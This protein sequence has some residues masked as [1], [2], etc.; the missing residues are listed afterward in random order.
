CLARGEFHHRGRKVEPAAIRNT[1]LLTVEGTRDDICG[2]GQTKAA[3]TLC[4]GIA[5]GFERRH[6]QVDTGHYGVFSGS[7]WQKEI[8]PTVRDVIRASN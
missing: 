2:I 5:A 7:R 1:A 8:Y 3:H 6:Q 4:T